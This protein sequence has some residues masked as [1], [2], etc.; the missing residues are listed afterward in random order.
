VVF[1]AKTFSVAE[2]GHGG[3]SRALRAA[4]QGLVLVSRRN[5]PAAWLVSAEKLAQ[6]AM[7][8]GSEQ[9]D[10]YRRVLQLLA[11]ELYRDD[12]LTLG[13]SATLAGLVLSDFIDLCG[14]L[15]VPILWEPPDGIDADADALATIPA[16]AQSAR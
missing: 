10:A 5:R 6:V 15:D 2:L 13:Q 8:L 1:V 4:E 14:R 9:A 11:V 12:L 16:D 7:V 3:A